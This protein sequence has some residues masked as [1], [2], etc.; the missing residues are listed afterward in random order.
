MLEPGEFTLAVG[1]S[2]RDLRLTA[3]IDVDRAPAAVPL[4]AMSTLQEWL[5]DPG[6]RR[7]PRAATAAGAAPILGND[8][9]RADRQLPAQPPR[10][11]SR[12]GITHEV[13][14][15]LGVT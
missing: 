11:V 12:L 13:L 15:R 2:S 4:D 8:E 5:A 7:P 6:R 10:R 9:L 14:H 3:A 1:A